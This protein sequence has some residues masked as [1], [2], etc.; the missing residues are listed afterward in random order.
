MLFFKNVKPEFWE[1]SRTR[2]YAPKPGVTDHRSPI[3]T[4]YR[5]YGLKW[6]KRG[7][8]H[9]NWLTVTLCNVNLSDKVGWSRDAKSRTIILFLEYFLERFE[10]V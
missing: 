7:F 2:L 10:H 5:T 4:K 6:F 1:D 9:K 8:T 3:K